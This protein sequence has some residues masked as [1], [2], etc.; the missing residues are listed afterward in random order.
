MNNDTLKNKT[1]LVI[2]VTLLTMFLEI[3]CGN[4]DESVIEKVFEEKIREY[5]G[6]TL[7]ACGLKLVE[8]FY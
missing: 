1:F 5:A 3:G 7:P 2:I 8:V 6:P 4:L